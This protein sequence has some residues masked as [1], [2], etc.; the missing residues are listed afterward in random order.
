MSNISLQTKIIIGA[1]ITIGIFMLFSFLFKSQQVE[2]TTQDRVRN[3]VSDENPLLVQI[4]KKAPFD[5]AVTE[6]KNDVGEIGGYFAEYNWKPGTDMMN[7]PPAYL[8]DAKGERSGTADFYNSEEKNN[9]L[10]SAHDKLKK[11]F[12]VTREVKCT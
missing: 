9:E 6:Y 10:N 2:E 8:Y 4:C 12:P 3:L 11:E 7:H 1:L 5:M